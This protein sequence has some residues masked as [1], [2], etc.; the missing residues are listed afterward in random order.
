M[1]K[2]NLTPGDTFILPT[3]SGVVSGRA[4]LSRAEGSHN[5]QGL[6]DKDAE[7]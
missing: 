2:H 6:N 3:W 1:A 5:Q 7:I 4:G